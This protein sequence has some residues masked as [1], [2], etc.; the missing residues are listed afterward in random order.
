MSFTV[1]AT[2]TSM[3]QW[4]Q[5]CVYEAEVNTFYSEYGQYKHTVYLIV[6]TPVMTF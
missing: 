2:L 1:I 5:S 4:E 3:H 6:T